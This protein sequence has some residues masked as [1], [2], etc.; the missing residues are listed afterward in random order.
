MYF[1]PTDEDLSEGTPGNHPSE[2]RSFAGDAGQEK[3]T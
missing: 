1:H 2:Q 3:A